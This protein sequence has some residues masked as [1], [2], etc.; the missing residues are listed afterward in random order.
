MKVMQGLQRNKI[1]ALAL[2]FTGLA[3]AVTGVSMNMATGGNFID[4]SLVYYTVQTNFMSAMIFLTLVVMTMVQIIRPI[5][6]GRFIHFKKSDGSN[7]LV[8]SEKGIMGKVAYIQPAFQMAFTLYI[9]VTMLIYWAL[10]APLGFSTDPYALATNL[11]M[12]TVVPILVIVDT[13]LFMPHGKIKFR[14]AFLWL[15]YPLI[16]YIFLVIR[17][18]F[19]DPLYNTADG[20][21]FYY[22][23]PFIDPNSFSNDWLLVPIIIGLAVFLIG[24]GTMYIFVDKMLGKS[25]IK[26]IDSITSKLSDEEV[27]EGSHID[28]YM[29]DDGSHVP[30]HVDSNDT[31]NTDRTEK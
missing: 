16:Y 4:N 19:G 3:L 5:T 11:I 15:I 13:F 22:P 21:L 14:N 28:N 10:L 24:L 20:A 1:A 7:D 29:V 18:Q 9:T 17:A 30:S 23:Y 25:T 26:D 8:L 2:R 31:S 12:H 6:L 27:L